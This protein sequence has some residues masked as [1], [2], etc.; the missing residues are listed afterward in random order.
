MVVGPIT[1]PNDPTFSGGVAW[2]TSIKYFKDSICPKARVDLSL[3]PDPRLNKKSTGFSC[4]SSDFKKLAIQT[5]ETATVGFQVFNELFIAVIP[6]GDFKRMMIMLK[7]GFNA[8]PGAFGYFV[9]AGYY[10]A[11]EV[12]VGDTLCEIAG[13]F[14]VVTNIFSAV[15]NFA[16]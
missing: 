2:T 14:Y 11:N 4:S 10:M 16:G 8:G 13:Y 1:I 12:N 6:A 15:A 5:W 7:R 9:A 3:F